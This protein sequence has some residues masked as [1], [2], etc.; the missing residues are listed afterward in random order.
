MRMFTRAIGPLCVRGSE[1]R[2]ARV[3]EVIAGFGLS[4]E[5]VGEIFGDRR[6]ALAVPRWSVRASLLAFT[7]S[8]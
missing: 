3:T 6:A 5:L 7:L 2:A 1:R 8:P 4:G